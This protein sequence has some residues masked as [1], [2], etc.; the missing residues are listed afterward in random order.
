MNKKIII[1]ILLAGILGIIS[2]YFL[3][4]QY[5]IKIQLQ[6]KESH[7]KLITDE[8]KEH[9]QT[10]KDELYYCP[11]HPGFVSDKP[12]ECSICGMKL[13]KKEE[14]EKIEKEA[15]TAEE[16]CILHNCEM[17]K[18]EMKI[19]SDIKNCPF[20]GK[21]ITK[22]EKVLYYADPD[23]S[24]HTAHTPQKNATGK[25]YVPVYEEEKKKNI[26]KDVNISPEKQQL[27]GIKKDKIQE[28]V[29]TKII[30]TVGKVAYDPDLFIA[31]Q[32]YLQVLKAEEN[33]QGASIEFIKEQTK[34]LV[35]AAKQKLLLS[36]MNER[37]IEELAE[38][39][40]AQKNLYLPTL[41]ETVWIYMTIYEYEIGL[42]KEGQLVE[43]ESVAYPGKIF[44]G[45]IASTSPVL[46]PN[47]RSLKIR[48]EV[49]NPGNLL[50]PDMY[51]NA[52]IKINLGK[53][54]AVPDEAVMDTGER[55]IIFIVKPKGYFESRE[56][57]L[58]QKAGNYY[59]VIKGI[60]SGEIVVTSGNFFIDSE[61]R[62]KSAVSGEMHKH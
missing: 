46:D 19:T 32:E 16:I 57:K 8:H 3:G 15:D 48:A 2:G 17:T 23:N 34:S 30:D 39:G 13:V 55:K 33:T 25:K 4:Q 56:V 43:I 31:Q 28:R 5:Q 36:G 45:K 61:T 58:G 14:A 40:K 37:Q 59:E 50:K 1:I 35:N 62:L 29:L 12:G 11:M 10:T 44:E 9:A 24:E 52:K 21:H 53:K 22:G 6:K 20:C 47:T 60:S 7:E 51:V 49:K 54:I 18:C 38:L 41:G 27:I 26:S 42:V